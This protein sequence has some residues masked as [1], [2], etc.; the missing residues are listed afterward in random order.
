VSLNGDTLEALYVA[1]HDLI[2]A[3]EAYDD[4]IEAWI[5]AT[6]KSSTSGQPVPPDIRN[7]L[8]LAAALRTVCINDIRN[9]LGRT[10]VDRPRTRHAL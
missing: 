2:D 6:E 7:D 8:E 1:G 10:P 5:A 3:D 9:I 4:A